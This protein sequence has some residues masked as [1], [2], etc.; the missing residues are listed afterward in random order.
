MLGAFGQRAINECHLDEW[1]Q[2]RQRGVQHIDR[3]KSFE[4]NAAQLFKDRR[5]AVGL[6]VFLI[7]D[8]VHRD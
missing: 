7:A 6:V 5:G 4:D 3:T 1:P 8:P 2:R